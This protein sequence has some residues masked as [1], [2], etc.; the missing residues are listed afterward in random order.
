MIANEFTI[1]GIEKS[2]PGSLQNTVATLDI[3]EAKDNIKYLRNLW[4][5]DN[6]TTWSV[7]QVKVFF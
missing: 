7:L 6:D 4:Y 1:A 3:G 2:S 5:M